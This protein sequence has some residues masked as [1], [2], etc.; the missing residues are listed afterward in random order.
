M[1]S[2]SPFSQLSDWWISEIFEIILLTSLRLVYRPTEILTVAAGP[3]SHGAVADILD[4]RTRKPEYL[5]KETRTLSL[6]SNVDPRHLWSDR[7]M[8]GVT[9]KL[10]AFGDI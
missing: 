9:F 4:I 6:R 2:G 5:D 10:S 8:L 7:V 1:R 3:V